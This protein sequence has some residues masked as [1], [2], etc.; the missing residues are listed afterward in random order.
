[1]SDEPINPSNEKTLE[2]TGEGPGIVGYLSKRRKRLAIFALGSIAIWAAWRYSIFDPAQAALE[3]HDFV[4]AGYVRI[5]P[6]IV[7]SRD[8]DGWTLLYAAAYGDHPEIVKF[9]IESG[10]DPNM[11]ILNDRY[12]RRPVHAAADQGSA[13]AM[14]ALA[15]GGADLNAQDSWFAQSPIVIASSRGHTNVMRVLLNAGV[16]PNA[17]DWRQDFDSSE[18]EPSIWAIEWAAIHGHAEVVELLIEG[19]AKVKFVEDTNVMD[20]FCS[21]TPDPK[22]MQEQYDEWLAAMPRIVDLL[23]NELGDVNYRDHPRDNTPLHEAAGN[24]TTSSDDIMRYLVENYPELDVN[25]KGYFGETPLHA[26]MVHPKQLHSVKFLVENCPNLDVNATDDSK[27]TPLHKSAT[28]GNVAGIRYLLENCPTLNVNA[29]DYRG[30]TPL[31]TARWER[32][33][34]KTEHNQKEVAAFTEIMELL[35]AHGGRI[36]EE[37]KRKPG[38]PIH[39]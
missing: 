39:D 14:K 35:E 13:R 30:F 20:T 32:P 27:R 9:L 22:H 24:L 25:A 7:N 21:L 2:P 23:V 36:D 31:N 38:M 5:D 33:S 18:M 4:V 17:H 29:I 28:H 6:G 26:A 10:A 12:A 16:D 15:E 19:G 3:G 8:E 37:A 1:M 11:S 34:A